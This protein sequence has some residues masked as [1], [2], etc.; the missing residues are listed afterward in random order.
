MTPESSMLAAR[1][2]SFSATSCLDGGRP[3]HG[4]AGLGELEF[5]TLAE[6][7]EMAQASRGQDASTLGRLRPQAVRSARTR[8]SSVSV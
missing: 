7:A 2:A 6:V 1:G 8:A 4:K 3:D 5:F